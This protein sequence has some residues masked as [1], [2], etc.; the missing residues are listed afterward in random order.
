MGNNSE[1]MLGMAENLW[2]GF[3]RTKV[4]EMLGSYLSYYRAKV[5][6]AP[7]NG[8]IKVQEPFDHAHVI[9]CAA[10]ASGLQAGDECI[11]L[12]F[13]GPQN[14]IVIGNGTLS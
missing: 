6:E 11:V 7:A 14:S 2:N 9:A 8:T 4:K 13:G 3:F 10:S 1:A 12:M 5:I